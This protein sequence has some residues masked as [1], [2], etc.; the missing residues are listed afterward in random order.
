[1]KL[2]FL[3][4][5][6]VVLD[7]GALTATAH[8][9]MS[10]YDRT[11]LV[12]IKGAVTQVDWLNPHV[13]I[14]LDVRTENGQNVKRWIE[15]VPPGVL[16]RKGF[17]RNLLSIG[18]SCSIGSV[19]PAGAARLKACLTPCMAASRSSGL[20]TSRTQCSTSASEMFTSSGSRAISRW[21][22]SNSRSSGRIWEISG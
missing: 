19:L 17:D 20:T 16:T 1:M 13:R 15:V 5:A 21:A 3:L 6:L 8:H 11:T 2:R 7:I 18:T 10:A 9:S 22:P 12:T 4:V 14:Q